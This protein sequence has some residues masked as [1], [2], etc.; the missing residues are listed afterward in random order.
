[1]WID[2]DGKWGGVTD[3]TMTVWT[4]VYP[5][6]VPSLMDPK[7]L[8]RHAST[9]S[10]PTLGVSDGLEVDEGHQGEHELAQGRNCHERKE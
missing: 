9:F 10:S 8:A 2:D 4:V 3:E 1:M 7:H 6:P 5:N